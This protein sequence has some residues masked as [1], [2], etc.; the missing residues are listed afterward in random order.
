MSSTETRIIDKA[1]FRKK[2]E[3]L[4]T[5][6][7][8]PH[9][10][11]TFTTMVDDPNVSLSALGEELAKDAALASKVL[12]LVNSSFYGF[13]GRISTVNQAAVLLGANA[14]RGLV[15]TTTV[16][17]ALTPEAYPLWRHSLLASLAC[18][19]IGTRMEIPDVEE[20]AIAALLHDIGKVILFLEV[21]EEYRAVRQSALDNERPI[22]AAERAMMGFD[23]SDIGA[24]LCEKWD[25]PTRLAEPIS[26]H[27]KPD[28][29][30]EHG[31]MTAG[32]T[33]GD[34]VVRGDG[35]SAEGNLPL[36]KLDPVIGEQLKLRRRD[37][38]ELVDK[39]M[40][41]MEALKG[42]GP[43]DIS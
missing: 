36:E 24:W 4:T 2:V 22:W 37:L 15:L 20:V 34:M 12:R 13:P 32:V 40:P 33:L 30:V 42:M 1:A 25:L 28:Q 17:D 41:E 23:H 21:P 16:F 19:I 26:C 27:H 6:P 43:G 9:L 39:I 31:I 11:E 14:L 7:S 38:E 29:S 3:R 18:R 35:S 10:M 8:L 5:L